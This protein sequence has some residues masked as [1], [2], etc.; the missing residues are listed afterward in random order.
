MSHADA[1][2]FWDDAAPE[3]ELLELWFHTDVQGAI[4]LGSSG[5]PQK[6]GGV[7][8]PDLRRLL[9]MALP[10]PAEAAPVIEP[11]ARRRGRPPKTAEG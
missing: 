7:T 3:A 5:L 8:S 4:R 10:A 1:K 11:V 6:N 2:Q 9:Q